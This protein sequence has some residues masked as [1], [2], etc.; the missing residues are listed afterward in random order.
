MCK[1]ERETG[2]DGLIVP[3]VEHATDVA[4]PTRA[5]REGSAAD[6]PGPSRGRALRT[7]AGG[8]MVGLVAAF[9]G[10]CSASTS[11]RASGEERSTMRPVGLLT[12]ARVDVPRGAAA[13]S[14]PVALWVPAALVRGLDRT[15]EASV[16]LIVF[17]H[18]SGESG[19]DG[20]RPT[21]VG[22]VRRAMEELPSQRT[23]GGANPW[24]RFVILAIQKPSSMVRWVDE[25]DVVLAAVR[26]VLADAEFGRRID[27]TRIYLTGLSQGGAGAWQISAGAPR[28]FA[29]I[30]P[31]CG[32]VHAAAPDED[33]FSNEPAAIDAV[34]QALGA[35]GTPVWAF[36]GLKDDV[37]PP[38]HTTRLIEAVR[39]T[40]GARATSGASADSSESSLR[41]TLLPEANHNAWDPAYDN[42]ELPGWLLRHRLT[43]ED[44]KAAWGR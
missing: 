34:A 29:A 31:V 20:V 43:R 42:S 12:M 4:R 11:E 28:H 35:A 41:V 26:S 16:P 23:G 33:R 36:H 38:V 14:R 30:A 39:A 6:T 5:R 27:T 9:A 22:L 8:L 2:D 1:T 3:A 15:P 21:H 40:A 32:F 18:G 17:L 7:L 13:V 37:V 19:T 10:G 24:D 44:A 25:A